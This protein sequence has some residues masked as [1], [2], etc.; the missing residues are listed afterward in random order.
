MQNIISICIPT[1]NRCDYFCKAIASI[2]AA[3]IDHSLIEICVS[4]N[5]SET[6]YSEALDLI[7]KAPKDILIKYIEQKKRLSIDENMLHVTNLSTSP[8]IYFLGDDD[9]FIKDQINLLID[10]IRNE[11]PDLAIFNGLLIDKF[12]HIIG[13]HF[14]IKPQIYN[15]IDTAFYNLR[16]KGT[17]GSVL[18]KKKYINNKNFNLLMG[19]SHAYGCYWF[20]FLSKL[21][22]KQNF[23]IVVPDFPLVALRM[24]EKNYNYL[25][26]YYRDIPYEI[27]I[28]KRYLEPGLPQKL[29]EK[30]RLNYYRNVSSFRFFC[31]LA[32]A[33]VQINNILDINPYF[34]STNKI[35]IKISLFIVKT[36][37]YYLFRYYYR[38]ISQLRIMKKYD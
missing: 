36:N 2:F 7:K 6:D 26:V 25:E 11:S 29:N 21:S 1:L 37:I 27:E 12:D 20:S 30:F 15:D 8:Y 19:T 9:Y 38:A 31:Q 4:N 17:F 16:D 35:K 23:K 22:Y 34:Y 10:F 24:A 14:K 18:V 32:E 3:D 28:Y 33:G 5:A 13:N